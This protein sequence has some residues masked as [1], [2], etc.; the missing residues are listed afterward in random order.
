MINN[1]H[2]RG[3]FTSSEIVALTKLAKDGKS[4]GAPALTYIEEKNMERKLGRSIDSELHAKPLV[5]GNL[6]E[7]YWFDKLGLEYTLSSTETD[8]HPTIKF[9]SG[10]SDGMKKDTVID[11]KSPI[12]LKSFCQLVDP[13]YEGY[14]G[15]DAM[16]IVRETHK[17]GDKYYW[18]LVS[19]SILKSTRYAELIVGVPYLS[20]LP[21]IKLLADGNPNCYWIAMAIEDELPFLLDG[22]YYKDVNI[23]RFEVPQ[24]DKDFLT[25]QVIKAGK[26]LIDRHS[27]NTAD[28]V[29]NTEQTP[30]FDINT[31]PLIK[32]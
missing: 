8:V 19:N 1:I 9:W 13:L 3:N 26:M 16:N 23:I 25:D 6:L 18:Q 12:T 11:I 32:L 4:F 10:S 24:Q 31:I 7:G 14:T 30:K 5:W 2:R 29:A 17:D 21:A 22:G 28:T 20:D 27:S 15:M